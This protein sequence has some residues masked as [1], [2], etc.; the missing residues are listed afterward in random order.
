M[1]VENPIKLLRELKGAPLSV[2]FALAIVHQPVNAGWLE[3]VTGYSDQ[4]ITKAL[5][6]LV[7]FGYSLKLSGQQWQVAKN[8][9]LPLII[10]NR[11]NHDI[12]SSTTTTTDIEEDE[13]DE[14]KSAVAVAKIVKNEIFEMLE[15]VGIGEPVRSQLVKQDYM[16]VEY[17]K[18][19][20]RKWEK[21]EKGIGL[22]IYRLRNRDPIPR[23]YVD[24]DK[25][26]NR[27]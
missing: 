26:I 21:E 7:E 24:Y 1:N 19:H 6:L 20:I 12:L 14:E 25:F 4:A 3:M 2:L 10:E 16:T 13:D 15:D 22:L 17:L 18:Y 9:Q 8:I 5:R 27:Y 11:E 23:G